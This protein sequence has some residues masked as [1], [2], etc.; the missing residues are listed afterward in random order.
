MLNQIILGDC[1]E[2][3][4]SIETESVDMIFCDLPFGTTK[5]EWD[6]I[7]PFEP[8]WLQYERVIKPNGA[9]ILF[10]KP[11]FDKMLWVS[12]PKLY[13]YD[14]VW[15]KN[16]ATGH[17]N[18]GHMPMQAHE[19]LMVFYKQPPTYNAQ[20]SSGHKPMNLAVTKHSSTVYGTG[21]ETVNQAGSTKRLPRSVLYYPV[22]NNDDPER[23]HSN[24][25]PVDLCEYMIR[26]YT[27]EGETVLDNCSGGASIALAAI[28]TNRNFIAIEKNIKFVERSRQRV[29]R[30]QIVMNI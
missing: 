22:V 6:V 16:K 4:P 15:E 7:V 12:N 27:N 23:I 18:A 20:L 29:E 17:L 9:I 14:W 21:K 26:T 10:A 25:K 24:Q 30:G 11:P 28:N 1:L 5:S 19:Y 13:R 3:M 2:V 8:L